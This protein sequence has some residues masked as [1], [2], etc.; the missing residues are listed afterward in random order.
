MQKLCDMYKGAFFSKR[1]K[2][3][4]RV[5]VVCDAIEAVFKPQ[6]V[7]DVGCAT[8]DFVK[9]FHDKGMMASGIE[10]SENCLPFLVVPA[11]SVFILD[12]RKKF[13]WECDPFDVA[14]CF[15]VAEHIE[16]EYVEEFLDNL[17][18]LSQTIIM[19]YAPPGQGGHYHVNCQ[20]APY[21]LEKMAHRGFKHCPKLV[22]KLRVHWKPWGTKREIR[23]YY[24]HLLC[25]RG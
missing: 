22:E 10:G 20:H 21:W 8:G 4:W 19:S 14:I 12:L 17:V 1:H 7:V 18:L 9:G 2:L 5:P 15:E 11:A 16:E 6:S 24:N 23:S 25:F 3:A 13:R